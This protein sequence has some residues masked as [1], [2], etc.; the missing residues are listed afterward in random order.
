MSLIPAWRVADAQPGRVV[1]PDER[2][3]GIGSATFGAI[4][5]SALLRRG[6]K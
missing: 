4:G 1:A 6:A 3:G 5:L 2:L